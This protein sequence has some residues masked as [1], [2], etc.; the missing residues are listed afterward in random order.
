M[1][2]S[3]DDKCR[4]LHLYLDPNLQEIWKECLDSLDRSS[5]DANV[6]PFDKVALCFND[7]E[8]YTYQN[9]GVNATNGLPANENLVCMHSYIYELNPCNM[10]RAGIV[11]DAKW[12]KE[13][14]SVLRGKITEVR[15]NFKRSGNHDNVNP[16]LAWMGFTNDDVI[17]YSKIIFADGVL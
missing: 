8:N 17:L 7:Y 15:S 10:T 14:M 6:N 2:T 9:M 1:M 13:T 4:L 12:C 3:K 16:Y 11:R 5:I